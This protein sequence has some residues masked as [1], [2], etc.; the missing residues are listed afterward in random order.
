MTGICDGEAMTLRAFEDA[1]CT[2]ENIEMSEMVQL[3]QDDHMSC[4]TGECCYLGDDVGYSIIAN[5]DEN[6][7]Y[8]KYYNGDAGCLEED[9]LTGNDI[10]FD[11]CTSWGESDP[12]GMFW[13]ATTL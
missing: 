10:E 9:F 11:V 7:F 6:G 1:D 2:N 3:M 8:R 12:T 5:C 4:Y 13:L